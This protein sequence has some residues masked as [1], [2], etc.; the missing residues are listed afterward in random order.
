LPRSESCPACDAVS[1]ATPFAALQHHGHVV[2]RLLHLFVVA[3]VGL[4]DQLVDLAGAD[5]CQNTVAFTDRQQDGIQYRF[6]PSITLRL[7]PSN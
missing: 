7:L 1:R 5:L 2:D 3:V 4:R 6:T